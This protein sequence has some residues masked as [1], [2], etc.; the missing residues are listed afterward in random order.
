MS[1]ILRHKPE[2]IDAKLDTKGWLEIEI[3]IAGIKRKGHQMNRDILEEIVRDNDK[4][5]FILNKAGD[6]I[7]ANQGHSIEVE[8]DLTPIEPP[9][10]LYHGTVQKFI[11]SIQEKGL[12]KMDRQHVHL[13]ADRETAINVGGRRGKPIILKVRAGE[14]HRND[15]P[16]YQSANGVW[17][18]DTVK[19][20]FIEFK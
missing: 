20:E 4:K 11:D 19:P 16:Y 7:R 5:R 8:L 6:K 2:T 1:L 3:L 13:S 18:T 12:M 14:M 17:L 15:I 10:F 9:E